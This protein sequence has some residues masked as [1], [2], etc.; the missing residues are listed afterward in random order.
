MRML[1][2]LRTASLTSSGDDSLWSGMG[3]GS[4]EERADLMARSRPVRGLP[5]APGAPPRRYL[6]L[7]VARTEDSRV[8]PIVA[9]WEVTLRC[10]LAC[11]HC[12]S[13]AGHARPN[14]LSTRECLELVS[15]LAELGTREVALI[16]G[17]AYL[18]EDWLE[19]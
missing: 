19:I 4:P 6:P 12:G 7:A 17:E 16:G 5:L 14:E 2:T 18:R 11:R 15:Q 9:V 13:R 8:R 3:R 10:D 1:K